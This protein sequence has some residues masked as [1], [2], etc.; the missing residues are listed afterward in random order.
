MRQRSFVVG[1]G[2]F[3]A[4]TAA[5]LQYLT[6]RDGREM[7]VQCGRSDGKNL[8]LAQIVDFHAQ[9]R[10]LIA[11]LRRKDC[12]ASPENTVNPSPDSDFMG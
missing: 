12:P 9:N 1:K 11:P 10:L 6:T 5:P 2:I 4:E 3:A 8:T 7:H